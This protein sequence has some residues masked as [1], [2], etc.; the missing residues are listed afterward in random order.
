MLEM[1]KGQHIV[2]VLQLKQGAI[3]P[4]FSRWNASHPNPVVA[5]F[6]AEYCVQTHTPPNLPKHKQTNTSFA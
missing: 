3:L 5:H 6:M 2:H 4:V 1:P